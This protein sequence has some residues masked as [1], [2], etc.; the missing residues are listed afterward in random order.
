MSWLIC[1]LICIHVHYLIL[2]DSYIVFP[3]LFFY[4]LIYFHWRLITIQYC[5]GF[6]HT[7]TWIS[8]G[9]TW[10]PP[11]WTSL[12]PPSPPHQM[13]LLYLHVTWD[14]WLPCGRTRSCK[15]LLSLIIFHLIYISNLLTGLQAISFFLPQITRVTFLDKDWDLNKW[16]NIC[17]SR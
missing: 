7:L 10:V 9:C 4:Y 13:L 15:A 11:S 16:W 6:C 3:N 2:S 8:H 17:K 12:P 5:G 14:K 1:I